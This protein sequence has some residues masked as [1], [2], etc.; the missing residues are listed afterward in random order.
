MTKYDNINISS[1]RL[2]K[3]YCNSENDVVLL[4]KE[5]LIKLKKSQKTFNVSYIPN[6]LL[7]ENMKE[8]K[9]MAPIYRKL[10]TNIELPN[11]K[12]PNLEELDGKDKKKKSIQKFKSSYQQQYNKNNYFKFQLKK[13]Y[14]NENNNEDNNEFKTKI[15][16]KNN[17]DDDDDKNKAS[18]T[19]EFYKIFTSNKNI[20]N[21]TKPK[22]ELMDKEINYDLTS[23][24]KKSKDSNKKLKYNK[25]KCNS[26][27]LENENENENNEGKMKKQIL[28]NK[29]TKHSLINV[30]IKKTDDIVMLEPINT[31]KENP[32]RKKNISCSCYI[33]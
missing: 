11:I 1:Y 32:K 24:N 15:N 4:D 26:L 18:N 31:T 28:E 30:G 33:F 20:E 2:L 21:Y 14:K 3:D 10:L 13:T 22:Q 9:R 29:K 25:N 27:I 12:L 23:L 17:N 16:K 5:D 8:Q 19:D 7:K 6:S